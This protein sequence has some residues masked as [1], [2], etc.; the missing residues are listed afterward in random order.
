MDLDGTLVDSDAAV[1]RSW[2]RVCGDWGLDHDRVRRVQAGRSAAAVI[3]LV[4]PDLDA[5]A[6]ARIAEAQLAFQYDDLSDVVPAP[7]ALEL[8]AV[9]TGRGLPWAVV[10]SGDRRLASVRLAAADIAAPVLVTADDVTVAKPDPEGYLL[11]ARRIGATPNDCLVVED[12]AAGVE[13]GRRAGM[14]VAG[15]RGVEAD[16]AVGDLIGLAAWLT[17]AAG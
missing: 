16:L 5:A 15:V 3:R 13:A 11:A 9:I 10:T 1:A 8:L 6:V 2:E 7:G 12:A 14:R 17:I 4:A